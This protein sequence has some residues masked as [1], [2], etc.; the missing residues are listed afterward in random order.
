MEV[1]SLCYGKVFRLI[2]PFILS[3]NTTGPKQHGIYEF[4]SFTNSA[5]VS[6]ISMIFAKNYFIKHK[7][8]Q[9]LSN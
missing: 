5:V 2:I 1:Y 6:E 7:K 3:N 8:L 4:F 9:F